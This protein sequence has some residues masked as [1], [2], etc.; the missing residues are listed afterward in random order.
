M[1]QQRQ[2]L[3][4]LLG[5]LDTTTL[6]LDSH[7]LE[8]MSPRPPTYPASSESFA[9]TTGRVFDAIRP[10]EDAAS[11]TLDA[12]LQ[13]TRA[14]RLAQAKAHDA[15]ALGLDEVLAAIVARTWKAP[16]QTGTAGATQRAIALTVLR[17]LLSCATSRTSP[18]AVRG[19]CSVALD[20][21]SRWIR[22]HPATRDWDDAF[23]FASHAITAAATSSAS[24]ELPG[25]RALVLD[26]MGESEQR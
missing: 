24:F 9:G 2:A 21:I 22:A 18:L 4:A 10:I 14:A 3:Q 7:I 23:A 12:I 11:L 15:D 13:P 26:P 1:A 8:L 17:S 25:R 16:P 19:A 20:D 6:G 5:T